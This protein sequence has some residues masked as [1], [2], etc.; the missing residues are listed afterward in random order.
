MTEGGEGWSGRRTIGERWFHEDI[1]EHE[2][3]ECSGAE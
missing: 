3:G 2:E 1:E